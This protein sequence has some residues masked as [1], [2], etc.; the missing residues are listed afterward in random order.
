MAILMPALQT[1]RKIAASSACLANQR[2]LITGWILYADD[3]D[4]NLMNSMACYDT[5]TNKTPWVLRPKDAAGNNL[6]NSPA[7]ATITKEDRIRGIQ[8]GTM[9]PYVP[10]A[11]AYH[12]PGDDRWRTMPPPRDAWRSYSISYAFCSAQTYNVGYR[13][14]RKMSEVRNGALYYVFVEEEHNAGNYGENEGGWHIVTSATG[15]GGTND[16][17]N[18]NT[19]TLHDPLASYHNKSSTFAFADGHAERI[20]WRDR[21]TLEIIE[22]NK[23]GAGNFSWR[24]TTSAGNEDLKW[25]I[26]H[27]IERERVNR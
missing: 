12:C 15:S 8:A 13:P 10:N 25:L 3:N 16:P 17:A 18:P 9:W 21:R 20:T 2:S 7:P 5:A 23:R 26:D 4:G 11:N 22:T 1:A 6:S 27:G 14:Y 24:A 19:W